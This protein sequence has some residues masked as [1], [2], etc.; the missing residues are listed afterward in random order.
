MPEVHPAAA[1]CCHGR[2]CRPPCRAGRWVGAGGSRHHQL[3]FA[4]P[5]RKTVCRAKLLRLHTGRSAGHQ[6]PHHP[7]IQG[8]VPGEQPGALCPDRHPGGEPLGRTV[9]HL[10]LFDAG[11]SAPLQDLLRPVRKAHRAGRGCQRR[12]AAEPVHRPLHPAAHEVRGAAG[13][14]AQNRE[15]APR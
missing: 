7:E 5:G 13:A 6:K 3:R 14:A 11:V 4:A 1:K 9:E 8:G 12:A 15:C 10:F 2:R